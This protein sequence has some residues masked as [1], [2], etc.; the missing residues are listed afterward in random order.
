MV[1]VVA[2]VAVVEVAM[3]I[4]V[5]MVCVKVVKYKLTPEFLNQNVVSVTFTSISCCARKHNP[6][7]SHSPSSSV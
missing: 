7:N 2:A 1:V 6:A 3:V 4:M 5:I